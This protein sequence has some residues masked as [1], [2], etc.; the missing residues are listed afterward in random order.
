MAPTKTAKK[1]PAVVKAASPTNAAAAKK[2][3]PKA[4]SSAG[5][6]S[7]GGVDLTSVNPATAERVQNQS[8]AADGSGALAGV[9]MLW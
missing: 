5:T 8:N 4:P 3:L 6:G 9:G 1:P 2:T 7:G